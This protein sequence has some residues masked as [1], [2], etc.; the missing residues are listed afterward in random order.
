LMKAVIDGAER[1]ATTDVRNMS[2]RLCSTQFNFRTKMVTQVERFRS[3]A[4]KANAYG[5]TVGEDVAALVILAN[6]EWALSQDWGGE[7]R[8]A[9]RIIRAEFPY[10]IA[11]DAASCAKIM[12]HLAAADEA[13]DMRKSKLHSGM[14]NSAEEGLNY[15]GALVGS[16]QEEASGYGEAYATTSDSESSI[17]RS[18]RSRARSRRKDKKPSR[19]RSPS[20]SCS[21]SPPRRFKSKANRR[22]KK[23]SKHDSSGDD[24]NPCKYCKKFGRT[25]PHPRRKSATGTSGTTGGVPSGF[26]AR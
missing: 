8:D 11:H 17:E 6:V 15:L 19:R 25:K 7:F 26:V 13:H 14:A 24:E 2:V 20:S 21:P 22:T 12:C 5:V 18:V 3:Q 10:N 16:H 23:T 1:P 9:L 4:A